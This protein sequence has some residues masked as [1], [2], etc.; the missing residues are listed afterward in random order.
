MK[1]LFLLIVFLLGISQLSI[2]QRDS[3]GSFEFSLLGTEFV[4]RASFGVAVG[5]NKNWH[6]YFQIGFSVQAAV[7]QQQNTFG[8][9]VGSPYFSASAFTLNNTAQLYFI[10]NLSVEANAN[11]GWLNINLQDEDVQEFNPVFG[12]WEAETVVSENFRFLQGGLTLNYI[13]SKKTDTN[14]SIFARVLKN[15]AFGNVRFGGEDANSNF[16]YSLGLKINGF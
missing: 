15:Q 2:A 12:F 1:K 5:V 7:N 10:G 4:D 11:V 13:V 8:Y 14:I 16:Q 9:E 6:E 3:K